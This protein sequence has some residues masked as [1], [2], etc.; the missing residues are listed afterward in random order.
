MEEIRG[1]RV[2]ERG[3][4]DAADGLGGGRSTAFC[5]DFLQRL[6]DCRHCGSSL[7]LRAGN[8]SKPN[9]GR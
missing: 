2:I 1:V 8:N 3:Q 6:T 9:E 5:V 4:A 7:Q